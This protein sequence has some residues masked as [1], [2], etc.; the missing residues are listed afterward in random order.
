MALC[1]GTPHQTSL[2]RFASTLQQH[3]LDE[4]VSPQE[5]FPMFT[6]GVSIFLE[7][8]KI[9]PH[10]ELLA[11]GKLSVFDESMGRAAFVSHQWIGDG[12][13]D[14][15]FKQM[16]VLQDTL[17]NL[18]SGRSEVSVDLITEAVYFRS[19]APPAVTRWGDLRWDAGDALY[20]GLCR[21]QVITVS[22][23]VPASQRVRRCW[24]V[25]LVLRRD[26]RRSKRHEWPP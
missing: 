4:Q 6:M 17:T 22:E 26:V 5:T 12:H 24:L 8:T 9:Q 14:P 25:P 15:E 2:Q 13:P 11:A 23:R 7:M 1:T 16:K 21:R 18:I 10:E 20:L 19:K 3:K